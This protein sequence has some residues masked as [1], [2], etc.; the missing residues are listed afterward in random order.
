MPSGLERYPSCR[1]FVLADDRHASKSD[2]PSQWVRVHVFRGKIP[3]ETLL[4]Y[5]QSR[6]TYAQ[7]HRRRFRRW[8]SNRRIDVLA[9]HRS[10]VGHALSQWRNER[11]YPSLDTMLVWNCFYLVWVGVAHRGC[12]VPLAWRVVAQLSSTVRL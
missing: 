10:L 4:V 12:T 8:L 2:G 3:P 6:A 9:A 7:S 11:M 1:N 5:V